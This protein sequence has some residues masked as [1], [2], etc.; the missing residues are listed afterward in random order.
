MIKLPKYNKYSLNHEIYFISILIKLLLLY[1]SI[2]FMKILLA[3][4]LYRFPSSI[5]PTLL[6]YLTY[7]P[8]IQSHRKNTILALNTHDQS[9]GASKIAYQIAN[10]SRR[11]QLQNRKTNYCFKLS[12]KKRRLVRFCKIRSS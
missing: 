11:Q 1:K 3:K 10:Y 4:I 9:G 2:R 8:G 6:T 7:F 12:R 5:F